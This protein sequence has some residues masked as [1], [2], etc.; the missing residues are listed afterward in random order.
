MATASFKNN[1]DESF[2]LVLNLG[3]SSAKFSLFAG[4]HSA[5]ESNVAMPSGAALDEKAQTVTLALEEI[6][7]SEGLGVTLDQV[8]AIGHRVVHG[9][10][11]YGGSVLIDKDVERDIEKFAQYAPLHN[12]INLLGIR[13]VAKVCGTKVAQV[14]VFDTGFHQTIPEVAWRYPVPYDWH[15]R[16][17]IRRYGFHGVS[18]EY[19]TTRA[20]QLLRA[21]RDAF[22]GVI[23]HLGSGCSVTAVQDGKSVD[24]SMG[25][26]PLEGLMM[27]TRSGSI[28]P[29]ILLH[30]ERNC[31]FDNE[32]LTRALNYESGLAAVSG[33]PNDMRRI[34]S[35]AGSN[36]RAQMAVDMFVYRLQSCIASYFPHLRNP[37]ALVFTGGIGE[38]SA[39]IRA[40][41]V[42]KL[43]ALGCALDEGLNGAAKGDS[44]ISSADSKVRVLV[45]RAREDLFIAQE[46]A[47]VVA[48]KG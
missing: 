26:T 8:V 11:K 44:D 39:E 28:D 21:S 23:C 14:A 30:L 35:E 46:A 37:A 9:G 31:D 42:A 19:A 43:G 7:S 4:E 18:H 25:F 40:R 38:N 48:N 6:F 27:G 5:W 2:I 24:T 1:P 12:P 29:G 33:L 3:S 10:G 16:F 17:G 36:P 20:S 34:C 41:T 47:R 45:V 15:D 22:G 13:C 32:T